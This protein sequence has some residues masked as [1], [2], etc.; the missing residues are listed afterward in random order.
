MSIELK[1]KSAR[2][3]STTHARNLYEALIVGMDVVIHHEH[4][5]DKGTFYVAKSSEPDNIIGRVT[6]EDL[7]LIGEITAKVKVYAAIW[8]GLFHKI[9]AYSLAD[10]T[11]RAIEIFGTIPGD[12]Y[13][14]TDGEYECK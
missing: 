6:R 2:L 10:A 7:L 13:Q 12:I 3:I 1:G 4:H 11:A 8:G 5:V 9:A 14:L